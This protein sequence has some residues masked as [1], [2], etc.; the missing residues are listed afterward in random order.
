MNGSWVLTVEEWLRHIWF[1]RTFDRMAR[2]NSLERR[3]SDREQAR[4]MW[5]ARRL[6]V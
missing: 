5:K 2:K 3:L 1:I 4:R 6:Q